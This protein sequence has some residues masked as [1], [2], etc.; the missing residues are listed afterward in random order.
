MPTPFENTHGQLSSGVNL[1]ERRSYYTS[2]GRTSASRYA[3]GRRGREDR[4]SS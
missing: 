4:K 2:R 3:S 1:N